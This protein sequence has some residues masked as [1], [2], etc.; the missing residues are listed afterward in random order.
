MTLRPFTTKKVNDNVTLININDTGSESSDLWSAKQI[1][2]YIGTITGT[3]ATIVSATI[4]NLS[5]ILDV[6]GANN[7][8]YLRRAGGQWVG[9]SGSFTNQ[10]ATVDSLSSIGDVISVNPSAGDV[11]RF[12]GAD[13]VPIA[14]SAIALVS[15]SA[16]PVFPTAVTVNFVTHEKNSFNHD[17]QGYD[18]VNAQH[19]NIG[20]L[21]V[22]D[23]SGNMVFI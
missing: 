1:K 16:I 8:E 9:D 21:P 6:Q 14:I 12:N 17:I 18:A 3:G 5:S 10:S 22:V 20:P 19:Y 23:N 7:G 13:W 11:L 2:D 4:D 15:A